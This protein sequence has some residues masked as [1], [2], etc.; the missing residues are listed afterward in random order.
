M[1]Y[2]DDFGSF[3][4]VDD[5]EFVKRRH[6]SRGRPRKYEPSASSDDQAAQSAMR[7]SPSNQTQQTATA[8]AQ[9]TSTTQQ[10]H[11]MQDR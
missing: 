3:W 2:E 4:M 8:S 9:R 11:S 6:L 1:R 10:A 5:N 7:Q